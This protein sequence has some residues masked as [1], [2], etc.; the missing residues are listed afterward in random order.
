[1]APVEAREMR[2]LMQRKVNSDGSDPT[3]TNSSG[4]ENFV[5]GMKNLLNVTGMVAE[6]V[7]EVPT[8]VVEFGIRER[9]RD[10]SR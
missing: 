7:M 4:M 10:G 3:N 9:R 8:R 1:M 5:G 6:R 2:A